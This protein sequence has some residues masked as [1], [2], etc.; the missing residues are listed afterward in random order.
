MPLCT[1]AMVPSLLKW[2]C[3][4]TSLGIPCVAHLVCPMPA[5][6]G[7]VSPP[8]VRFSSTFSLP[9]AFCIL[10]FLPSNMA[11]PAESYP[12]YSSL[13]SPSS[14]IGA[15]FS[16]PIYPTIPHILLTCQLRPKPKRLSSL[17]TMFPIMYHTCGVSVKE[18][19]P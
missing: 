17:T 11:I 4:L 10:I 14:I 15:A 8:C 7:I 13:E 16:T 5:Y 1:T 18:F 19:I 2:G 3:E 12:L 6:P 9:T